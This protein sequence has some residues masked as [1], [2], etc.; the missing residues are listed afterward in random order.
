VSMIAEGDC[1]FEFRFCC[2]ESEFIY[3]W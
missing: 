2:F 1:C 3:Y